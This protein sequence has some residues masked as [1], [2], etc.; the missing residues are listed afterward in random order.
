MSKLSKRII[1][2]SVICILIALFVIFSILN[3]NSVKIPEGTVGADAGNLNNY[4]LF[5]ERDGKVYFSN[6]YDNGSLYVMNPDQSNIKKLAN[7]NARYINAGGNTVFFLG[8]PIAQSKGLGT[9]VSKPGIFSVT[10]DGRKFKSLLK[11]KTQSMLLLDNVI[12]YQHYTE[13]ES[14]TLYTHDLTSHSSKKTLNYMINPASYQ[15]GLIYFNGMYNDHYLYTL[16]VKNGE[17]T[18]VFTG[19][20][21][22]PVCIGDYVYYMDVKN[23]Y[24]LCR[25]NLS[26]N[27]VEILTH[28]RIDTFN[29][30]G[31]VIFYQKSSEKSPELKRMDLDGSN[32][33]TIASGVYNSINLTST[34]AYFKEFGNDSKT[35]YVPASGYGTVNE[36]IAAKEAVKKK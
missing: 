23:N 3:S 21:W 31:G 11:E 17:V 2:F 29:I 26:A 35:Y 14:T 30:G 22:N 4:G 8:K 25:I 6:A 9:V 18:T 5:C 33:A 15:N 20:L 28:D 32:V 16:N 19:D 13:K 1:L 10:K 27:V 36:F 24:R 12:F 7:I 34:Y